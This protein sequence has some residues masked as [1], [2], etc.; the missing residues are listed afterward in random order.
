MKGSSF[1]PIVALLILLQLAA[2]K[3]SCLATRPIPEKGDT[4][5]IKTSCNF[6][7]YPQLCYSSLSKYASEIQTSPKRLACTALSVTLEDAKSAST[8]LKELS[9]SQGLRSKEAAALKDCVELM[10]E[11]VDELQESL[12]EMGHIKAPDFELKMNNILTWVSAALTDDDT[13]MDGFAGNA[14]NGNVK[15]TVR[16]Q[17]GKVA[18]MTSIAL[19]LINKYASA[20]ITAY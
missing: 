9:K 11:S 14:A 13:C 10:S 8:T 2:Y 12:E 6:T 4:G 20:H 19:A 17:V 5:Y 7:L 16:K 18:H 3:N 15:T 1:F